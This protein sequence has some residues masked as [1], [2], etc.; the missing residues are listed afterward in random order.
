MNGNGFKCRG[1]FINVTS[2]IIRNKRAISTKDPE[3]TE[4]IDN[5]MDCDLVIWDDIGTTGLSKYEYDLIMDILNNRIALKKSNIFTSNADKEE[6][7][8]NLGERLTSR[9]YDSEVIRFVGPDRRGGRIWSN[10]K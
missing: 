3:L 7:I 1:V 10:C 9:V 6:M 2:F 5:L 4:I 8:K